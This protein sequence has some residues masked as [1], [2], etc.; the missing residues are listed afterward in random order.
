MPLIIFFKGLFFHKYCFSI[1]TCSTFAA[2]DWAWVVS[3]L[4]YM[5]HCCCG[6]VY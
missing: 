3:V 4:R 6:E 1:F 2:T 5:K